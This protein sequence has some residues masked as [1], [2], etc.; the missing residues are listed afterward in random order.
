MEGTPAVWNRNGRDT[1]STWLGV[2]QRA[3]ALEGGQKQQ[4]KG[5]MVPKGQAIFSFCPRNAHAAPA[6]SALAWCGY[7]AVQ[8]QV[9]TGSGLSPWHQSRVTG[10]FSPGVEEAMGRPRSAA[11]DTAA[12]VLVEPERD[13]GWQPS[14]CCPTASQAHAGPASTAIIP[15]H[16]SWLPNITSEKLGEAL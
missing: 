12:P 3:A 6:S 4:D 9:P 1:G 13:G 2:G 5:K 7:H 16:S 11:E 14:C 15:Q 8:H 10:F